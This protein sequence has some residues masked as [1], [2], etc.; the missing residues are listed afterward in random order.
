M[1]PDGSLGLYAAILSGGSK[2]GHAR[3]AY[4]IRSMRIFHS[5]SRAL[6]AAGIHDC[7]LMV[8]KMGAELM[9]CLVE[10][11]PPRQRTTP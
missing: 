2:G 6:T 7:A 1:D 5:I 3:P 8:R 9:W 10:G 11:F 4:S